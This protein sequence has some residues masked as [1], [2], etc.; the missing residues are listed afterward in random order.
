MV[1]S[2]VS[3]SI[4]ESGKG[5]I[6]FEKGRQPKGG[7]GGRHADARAIF[8]LRAHTTDTRRHDSD[9]VSDFLPGRG[10]SQSCNRAVTRRLCSLVFASATANRAGDAAA[11]LD[12]LAFTHLQSH[13]P[14]PSHLQSHG[15]LPSRSFLEQQPAPAQSVALACGGA[16]AR[17]WAVQRIRGRTARDRRSALGSRS[18]LLSGLRQG[19]PGVRLYAPRLGCYRAAI[20]AAARGQG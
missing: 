8:L 16:R 11:R 6:F 15:P 9:T 5:T 10:Q 18:A 17:G 20:H 4:N 19:R 1:I 3:I 13:G 2:D 7:M 12:A 14:L